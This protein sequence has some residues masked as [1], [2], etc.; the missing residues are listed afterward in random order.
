[1]LSDQSRKKNKDKD[2][3]N[4]FK[5]QKTGEYRFGD[6]KYVLHLSSGKNLTGATWP[7]TIAIPS[8]N[9]SYEIN[10]LLDSGALQA[11]YGSFALQDLLQAKGLRPNPCSDIICSAFG[12]CRR[13]R[14]Q[15]FLFVT[16]NF[17]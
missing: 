17:F 16:L 11:N 6:F 15:F 12:E 4:S 9:I 10:A 2:K 1:M 7:V 3:S 14:S 13:C 5:R 8:T